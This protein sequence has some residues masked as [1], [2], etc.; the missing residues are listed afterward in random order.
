MSDKTSVI[1]LE[2]IAN[3][4]KEGEI[5]E[6]SHAQA[7]NY[8]IPKGLAKLATPDVIK[9]EQEKKKRLQDNKSH[10]MEARHE[11]GKKLHNETI[12]FELA[13]SKDKIFGGI[14]EH[15]IIDRIKKTYDVALEKK[16]IVLP[17]GHHLKKVGITDIK[18]NLGSDVYV[19]M[20]IDIRSQS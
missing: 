2:R 6:V 11:I 18:I 9:R 5:V 19:K 17:E 20:H 15:E 14:A 8:L 16:H 7:K 1:L 12:V 4:G 13:G 3:I 10:L